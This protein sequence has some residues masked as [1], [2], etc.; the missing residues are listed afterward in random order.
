MAVV[1]D[2]D[3]RRRDPQ[4]DPSDLDAGGRALDALVRPC[5]RAVAGEPLRMGYD[6]RRRS[7]ALV[8]RHDPAVDAPTEI[9]VPRRAYP[10]GYDVE[11]SDGASEAL[12]DAQLL[13]YRHDAER[14]VHTVR[15]R[16]RR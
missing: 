15:I 3:A 16:R 11:L 2:V 7:F 14:P 8:F 9:F 1:G 10:R 6:R 5:V 4:S 13:L 12:P